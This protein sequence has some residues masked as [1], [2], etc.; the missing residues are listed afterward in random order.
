MTAASRYETIVADSA[1]AL[2]AW[3]DTTSAL[4]TPMQRMDEFLH[5]YETARNDILETAMQRAIAI[6]PENQAIKKQ[7][8]DVKSSELKKTGV[9]VALVAAGAVAA[10]MALP[11]LAPLIASL[12]MLTVAAR[13][14]HAFKTIGKA[15]KHLE[16][17]VRKQAARALQDAGLPRIA[18]DANAR[19]KTAV[20]E[21]AAHHFD[22]VKHT[23]TSLRQAAL[24]FA[25]DD[26][27]QAAPKTVVATPRALLGMDRQH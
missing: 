23:P 18:K 19:R 21:L 8:A 12:T 22:D 17:D 27:S 2:A 26:V 10:S 16:Q 6:A 24:L 7:Q 15:E 25:K 14:L 13:G 9:T 1:Q 4:P 20:K 11:V 3:H 5:S